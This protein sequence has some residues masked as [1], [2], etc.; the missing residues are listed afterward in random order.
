MDTRPVQVL[1]IEDSPTDAGLLRH[2]LAEARGRFDVE[3]VQRLEQ[4][5]ARLGDSEVDVALV[6]LSLPDSDGLASFRAVRAHAP[7]V[8]VIVLSGLDDDSVAI[9]AVNEG[10]QDYL[11]KGRAESDVLARAI[12]YA[13]ERHRLITDLRRLALVDELTGLHN[14]RGFVALGEHL[15]VLAERR[16]QAITVLFIDVDNMKAINDRYGHGEGDA[17]LVQVAQLLRGT[18]RASDV[19]A[20]VG[21]D[22]FCV[23]MLHD[24]V[25]DD[26]ALN[27]LREA[28]DARNRR[29]EHPYELSFSIGAARCQP[30]QDYAL[31]DLIEQADAA[32]YKEKTNRRGG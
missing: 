2:T 1:L 24:G 7:D 32:M 25:G 9:Q 12:R 13:I 8:P 5:L 31:G 17:A 23:L 20:R 6:D 26:L 19:L 3:C 14:R 28:L 30:G 22:E 18:F 27:R 21:G 4:G 10:A 11:V 15:A 29:A 16:S